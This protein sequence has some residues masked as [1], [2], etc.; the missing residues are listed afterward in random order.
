MVKF[1][2]ISINSYHF[3]SKGLLWPCDLCSDLHTVLLY[4]VVTCILHGSTKIPDQAELTDSPSTE[5]A[6]MISTSYIYTS[7]NI[8]I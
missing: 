2:V 5:S 3:H 8:L 1:Q 4:L 7:G 6:R